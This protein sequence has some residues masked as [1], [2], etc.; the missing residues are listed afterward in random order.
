MISIVFPF[1]L[2]FWPLKELDGSWCTLVDYV[3]VVAPIAAAIMPDVIFL[4]K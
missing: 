3:Q 4:L 2:Y 1:N